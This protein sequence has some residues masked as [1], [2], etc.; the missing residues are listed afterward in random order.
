MVRPMFRKSEMGPRGRRSY[1]ATVP[2]QEILPV[3]NSRFESSVRGIYVVGDVTGMP[4]VKVAS[5]QG[6]EVIR[7]MEADGVLGR[8]PDE[9]EHLDLVIIGGGPAGLAA[10]IEARRRQ[11]KYVVLERNKLTSTVRSFPP[12]KMVHAEP[13]GL[14]NASALPVENDLEKDQF[15]AMIS[16]AVDDHQL[17]V[18]ED[19]EVSRVR[20]QGERRFEVETASGERFPTRA[21]LVAVG[22]QGQPRLLECPGADLVHKV[23]YRLDSAEAYRG[24][25]VL[26]VGGGNSAIEAALLLLP[27]A[28][29]TLSYRG[30]DFFRAKAKNRRQLGRPRTPAGRRSCA[31]AD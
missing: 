9:D 14:A 10:A 17:K 22:R 11:L 3:V 23:T 18:R 27:H 8:R 6:A 29:V 20:K 28:R 5:N 2:P 1:I 7:R 26:I 21:V 30:N 16:R 15:L 4:L 25:E 19:T 12:G 13:Y 24:R 31:G